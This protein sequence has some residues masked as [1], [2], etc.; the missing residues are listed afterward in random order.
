VEGD[1]KTMMASIKTNGE[2]KKRASVNFMN[3]NAF[4]E[5]ITK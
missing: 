4:I 2:R 5:T 1:K 3:A